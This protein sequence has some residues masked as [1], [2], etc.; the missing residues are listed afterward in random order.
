MLRRRRLPLA[1]TTA[2][3]CGSLA[4]G[5]C[6]GGADAEGDSP[7]K[8]TPA[9]TASETSQ[10]SSPVTSA[11]A[12][13][14]GSSSSDEEPPD[15]YEIDCRRVPKKAVNT[16]LHGGQAP[17]T[18]P[19][20]QGCRVVSS[21]QDGAVIVEWRWLD[22]VGS[23]GDAGILRELETSGDP[24]T[25][26]PGITGTRIETDVAPTRKAQTAAKIKGR[27]LYVE[28][29]V[30]LDRSQSLK[31]LRRVTSGIVKAYEDATPNPRSEP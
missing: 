9:S 4:L 28:S 22:V 2:L 6:S 15:P 3:V 23:G 31:D 19:T 18:E 17:K 12:S 30:T 1:A 26:T 21:S 5:G 14:S 27:M 25:V 8:D 7:S 16:W 11:S 13:G 29:T 10:S 20:D 24:I